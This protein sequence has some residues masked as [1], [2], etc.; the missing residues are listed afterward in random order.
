MA[1]A[2]YINLM[3]RLFSYLQQCVDQH[4]D[5][6]RR[7]FLH[8]DVAVGAMFKSVQYQID[9]VIER[10]HKTGHIWISDGQ[11]ITVD[12]LAQEQRDH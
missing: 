3:I 6:S 10:H 9:R 1:G 12:D 4:I 2:N 11:R 5:S 8:K 7:R